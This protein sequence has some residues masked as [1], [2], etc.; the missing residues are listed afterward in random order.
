ML[1]PLI[2]IATVVMARISGRWR[3]SDAAFRRF[4]LFSGLA[5]ALV[6]ALSLAYSVVLTEQTRQL[7]Y[8]NTFTR[9][10]EFAAGALLAVVVAVRPSITQ[11][12]ATP[13]AAL[14]KSIA[15]WIGIGSIA[16]AALVYSDAS[17]FP[18]WLAIVPVGGAV[19]VMI[20]GA[21]AGRFS[22]LGIARLRPVQR[23]GD[24]SYAIYLWHW[25]LIVLFPFVFGREH[26][27]YTGIAILISSVVLGAMTKVIVE[28]PTRAFSWWSR[29]RWPAFAFAAATA[30]ILVGASAV[31][32]TGIDLRKAEAQEW[33]QAQLDQRAACFGA[34]AMAADA[35]CAARFDVG[36]RADL[37]FAATDLDKN[38]CLAAPNQD[39]AS[40]EYGDPSGRDGTIALV[41][42]SHAAALVPAFEGYFGPE[43]WKVVT[44]L[45]T[46]CPGLSPA[47][48][49]MP[50]RELW[51][52]QACADWSA[53][54]IDEIAARDDIDAVVFT[55]FSTRYADPAVAA[56]GR[57]QSSDIVATWDRLADSGKRIVYL[58]DS[59][60]LNR[61]H[62]PTCVATALLNVK[63]APCAF[64]RDAAV[65][66]DVITDAAEATPRVVLTDM[67]DFYCDDDRC[68][69]V[70]G[71]VVVYADDNH[72]SRTYASTLAPY[73]GERIRDAITR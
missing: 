47:P 43:G 73:L 68:Y 55:G 44:Y 32:S 15:A 64:D 40:C 45:R 59:P 54:V 7:A 12:G 16:T 17:P 23:I 69:S 37:A 35:N 71:D 67:T 26:G 62:V 46:G 38:W 48:I 29:V 51:E 3:S 34:A 56:T 70:I 66:D 33:A 20:G 19:L 21:T 11:P 61:V 5:L 25:P 50:G 36:V 60:N 65:R 30:A 72:V 8:F 41:G 28:D 24:W 2:I 53:R 27:V 63:S 58:R 13:R 10:W 39:W 1:W 4:L 18:G 49:D 6:F 57:I 52:Q 31:V 9:A 42:D 22:S 14:A